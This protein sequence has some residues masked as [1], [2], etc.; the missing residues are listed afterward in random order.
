MVGAGGMD[1]DGGVA[2]V[3]RAGSRAL[4]DLVLP[5]SCAGCARPGDVL[6]P[7]CR[8][9]LTRP[10]LA[11][12]RRHPPGFPPTV[13]AGAYAGPVRPTVLAFKEHGRAELAGPLGAALA[14]AVGVVLAGAAGPATAPVVLVPV[15]SS[16]AAVRQRGRDHVREL[17]D[18]AV[19]ELRAAG[20]PARTAPVLGRLRGRAGRTRDSAGL[21]AA[22]RRANLAGRFRVLPAGHRAWA[23]VPAGSRLVLV[24]DV[25]TSGATLTEGARALATAGDTPWRDTPVVAAVVAATPRRVHRPF[26]APPPGSFTVRG[27]A[28]AGP[29][30]AS[31]VGTGVQ[32]LASG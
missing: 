4:A 16:A 28:G 21:D 8:C 1:G 17:A 5:R 22:A 32:R 14:L 31:T 2:G 10:R 30:P 27:R 3:L 12:P 19:A 6:C 25:V 9:R 29:D 20:V 18:R 11:E 7:A 13:A 26:A 15:P 24:D 23:G